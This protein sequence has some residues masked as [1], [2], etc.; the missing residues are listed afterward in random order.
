MSNEKETLYLRD[1]VTCW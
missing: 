1:L